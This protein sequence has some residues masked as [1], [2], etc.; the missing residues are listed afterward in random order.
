MLSRITAAARTWD[1]TSR[2]S[3]APRDSAS[4]PTAPEPAYRSRTA[5]PASVPRIASVVAN[6]PSRARSLVGRVELPGGT[7]SRRPRAQP[8]RILVMPSRGSQPVRCPAARGS[9]L[10]VGAEEGAEHLDRDIAPT[11]DH[12][13]TRDG[14][15]HVPAGP[16]GRIGPD[17]HGATAR[18]PG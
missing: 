16:P 5:A 17:T 10:P 14:H 18:A 11:A 13:G 2:A 1:S 8:A 15:Q 9:R 3:A 4:S 6:S 7:A 12:E